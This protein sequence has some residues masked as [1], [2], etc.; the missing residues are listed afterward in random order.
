MK[1]R[2][3]SSSK[4]VKICVDPW[5]NSFRKIEIARFVIRNKA[6]P[7]YPE[8]SVL[9]L[10]PG[11]SHQVEVEMQIVQR[12]QAQSED[13]LGLDEMTDVTADEFATARA[14]AVFFD[15]FLIQRKLRIF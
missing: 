1:P 13:L 7:K 14:G 10:L 4:S 5:L 11:L 8:T 12:D 15:W 9:D 6:L 2:L 3:S